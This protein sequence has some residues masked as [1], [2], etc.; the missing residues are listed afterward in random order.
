ML[1]FKLCCNLICLGIHPRT[2]LIFP[3]FA[4][5]FNCNCNPLLE[6]SAVKESY[7]WHGGTG[8]RDISWL[9][10]MMVT[11]WRWA[12]K[13]GVSHS[14]EIALRIWLGWLKQHTLI[15]ILQRS[16]YQVCFLFHA[17]HQ[18]FFF[19]KKTILSAPKTLFTY[20]W[21]YLSFWEQFV[22][23]TWIYTV[24]NSK[25]VSQIFWKKVMLLNFFSSK[26]KLIWLQIRHF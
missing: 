18:R 19:G 4:H 3:P 16:R 13:W 15:H 1:T 12:G 21:L 7:G 22:I 26:G 24:L 25:R 5:Y 8:H 20:I 6:L 14:W 17:F 11:R 23:Y 9:L 10:G 2:F